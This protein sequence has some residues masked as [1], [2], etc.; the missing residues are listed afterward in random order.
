MVSVWT[1]N[2]YVKQRDHLIIFVEQ[3]SSFKTKTLFRIGRLLVETDLTP[4]MDLRELAE[5]K[6]QM[7][8][9]AVLSL[10]TIAIL[11]RM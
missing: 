5:S 10:P 2:W 3:L 1:L 7:F 11:S 8:C 6:D 4:W 9:R